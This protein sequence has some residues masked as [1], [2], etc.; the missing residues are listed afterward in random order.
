MVLC[1]L[2]LSGRLSWPELLHEFIMRVWWVILGNTELRMGLHGYTGRKRYRAG[3]LS[4][5][6]SKAKRGSAVAVCGTF[7]LDAIRG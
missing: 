4:V 1:A 3:T 5:Q 2:V 7:A 6:I